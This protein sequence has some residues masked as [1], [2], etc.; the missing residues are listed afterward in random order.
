MAISL[1]SCCDRSWP[2]TIAMLS[3]RREDE[4]GGEEEEVWTRLIRQ[5]RVTCIAIT[6]CLSSG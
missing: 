4:G 1:N 6:N 2:V 5:S 3:R